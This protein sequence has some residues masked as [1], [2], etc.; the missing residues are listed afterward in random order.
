VREANL[1]GVTVLA[2]SRDDARE[3]LPAFDVFALSSRFEGLSIALVEAMAAGLPCVA[4][5]VGGVPEV[6]EHSGAGILV[7]ARQEGSFAAAL[8]EV[9]ADSALRQR[10]S[11]A[12]RV[13]ALAFDVRSAVHQIEAIYERVLAS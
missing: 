13:R 9:L 2:G 1:D 3:L 4:T 11:R 10:M 6:V 5:R 8:R 12:A 7:P